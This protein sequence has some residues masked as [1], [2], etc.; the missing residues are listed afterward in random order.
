MRVLI[1]LSKHKH[2]ENE[3]KYMSWIRNLKG[4]R[5]THNTACIH[6]VYKRH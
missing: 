3:I 1:Y 4:A 5:I 6:E 2:F